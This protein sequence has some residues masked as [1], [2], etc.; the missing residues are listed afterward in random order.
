MACEAGVIE[1]MMRS[2]RPREVKR[3]NPA[4]VAPKILLLP[5]QADFLLL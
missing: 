5:Y 3:L 4:W 1:P 2:L